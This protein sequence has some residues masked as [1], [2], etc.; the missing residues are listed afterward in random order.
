MGK[1]QVLIEELDDTFHELYITDDLDEARRYYNHVRSSQNFKVR[2]LAV[3]NDTPEVLMQAVDV[4][5]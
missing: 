1:F 3:K 2:L 5:H 4:L